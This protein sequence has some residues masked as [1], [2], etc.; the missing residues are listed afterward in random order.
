MLPLEVGLKYVYTLSKDKAET[1]FF[2]Y[3]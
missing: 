1:V 2:I 3:T